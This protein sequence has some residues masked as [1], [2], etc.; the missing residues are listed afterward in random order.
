MVIMRALLLLAGA[1]ALWAQADLETLLRRISEE[2]EVFRRRAPQ[3][4][5]EE[6][7]Q[8]KAVRSTPRFYPRIGAAA[9]RPRP[10]AVQTRVIV[11][12]YSLG[13]LRESGQEGVLHEF[14]KVIS[15]DGRSVT[16]AAE[17]RHALSLGLRSPDDR[18]RK[19][20][21]EEFQRYGLIGAVTD[22]APLILLFTKRGIGNYEIALAGQNRVAGQLAR[23][24]DYRQT[25]GAQSLL[26]FQ[27]RKVVRHSMQGK[28]F[29]RASDGLPLRVTLESSHQDGKHLFR[30]EAAVEYAVNP[31]G[32][33][34]PVSVV[35]RGFADGQQQVENIFGYGPF[36]LFTAATEIKFTETPPEP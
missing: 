22:F 18:V 9:A 29:V 21:L 35:H 31:H 6:T 34:A 26:I 32:F 14:R 13:L 30:D 4:L 15:V 5:A 33:L 16:S 20:L 8:Q 27:G 1:T 3:A 25:A 11:S 23:V 36:R 17:A 19:R 28:I 2:A 7:L 24:L 10:R 12:E